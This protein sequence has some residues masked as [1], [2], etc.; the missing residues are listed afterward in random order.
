MHACNISNAKIVSKLLQ[1]QS[2]DVNKQMDTS[3]FLSSAP[4]FQKPSLNTALH[5]AAM[6]KNIDLYRILINHGADKT[7][8]N[9]NDKTPIQYFN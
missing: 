5:I 6:R 7:I 3:D 9:K 2:I 4:I 8:K 1:F